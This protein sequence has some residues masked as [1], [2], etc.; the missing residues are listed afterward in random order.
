M[1]VHP[2][3]AALLVELVEHRSAAVESSRRPAR[4]VHAPASA[5]DAALERPPPALARRLDRQVDQ[6]ADHEARARA[7]RRGP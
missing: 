3:H 6:V 1:P 7:P 4:V 2:D 5:A